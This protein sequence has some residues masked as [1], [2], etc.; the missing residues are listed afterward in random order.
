[1]TI[2]VDNDGFTITSGVKILDFEIDTTGVKNLFV[3]NCTPIESKQ[4]T[5][6]I[7]NCTTV[8]CTTVNCTTVDCTTIDCT[9]I[10]CN[11]IKCLDQNNCKCD[12]CVDCNSDS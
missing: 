6:T 10:E 2:N 12:Y 1:M 7:G 3:S 4:Q 11:V 5:Y 8:N 9:T